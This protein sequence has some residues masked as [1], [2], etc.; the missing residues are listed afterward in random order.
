MRI[1]IVGAAGQLG[2][3]LNELLREQGNDAGSVPDEFMGASIETADQQ[4]LDI[5]DEEAVALFFE[6]SEP[7]DVVFNCAA[8][9][10][11]DGCEAN[12]SLAYA[13][14]SNGPKILAE[15]CRESGATFVHVSTD[16][17]FS[18]IEPGD[19]RESDPCRPLSVYGKSKLEGERAAVVQNPKTH[20]V[21]TAWLYGKRGRNFLR[22]M[23]HLGSSRSS[24][25]V[26]DDQWGNPTNASDLALALL[27]VALSPE[28]SIWHAS[29]EG[30]CTWADFSRAIMD[31]FGLDCCVRGCSSAQWKE[32]HPDSAVRPKYSSLDCRKLAKLG[33]SMR[34]WRV[35]LSSFVEK[36]KNCKEREEC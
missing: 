30:T 17:V 29:C 32:M 1:L 35:A 12:P 36:E 15:A 3:E 23:Q 33:F 25:V 19:R 2:S 5:S 20:I 31:D 6:S 18:G 34:P 13:V 24:V 14:N 11:V 28:Y 7:F 8:Y 26:V 9:T 27:H 22:T 21:R 4:R 16:Y 10:N